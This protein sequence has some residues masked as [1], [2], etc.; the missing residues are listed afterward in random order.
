[1]MMIWILTPV[2]STDKHNDPRSYALLYFPVSSW[3]IWRMRSHS[4]GEPEYIWWYFWGCWHVDWRDE[5]ETLFRCFWYWVYF[6]LFQA[7][8]TRR[9]HSWVVKFMMNNAWLFKRCTVTPTDTVLRNCTLSI[10]HQASSSI[11]SVCYVRIRTFV[12]GIEETLVW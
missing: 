2:V 10:D 5:V 1:M 11:H 6:V 12:I 9:S 3:Q 7:E 4:H 8:R